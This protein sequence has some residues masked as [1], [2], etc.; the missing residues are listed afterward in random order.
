MPILA[1][2]K[3]ARFDYEFLDTFEAGIML[4][5]AEVKSAKAGQ[6]NLKGSY[7]NI[8]SVKH[9]L[10]EVQL[11]GTHIA[12]YKYA[13]EQKDY[14]PIRSRKLLLNK[15]EIETLLG[16]QK[17][18]GLTLVPIKLYTK[19][20]LIKL[21]FAVAKGKK[22]YDKREDKKQKDIS[23]DLKRELKEH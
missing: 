15:K 8:K 4:T 6:V 13:G 18:K 7:I 22:N 16:K 12:P 14:D 3:K 20:S 5:G 23:R 17:E 1:I 2:N 9:G 19:G 11:I 10:P 21:E